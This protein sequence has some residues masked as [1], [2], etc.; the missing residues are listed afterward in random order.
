MRCTAFA[1]KVYRIVSEI[2][3]G[4]V[5]TYQ[6]VAKK[7]GNP[8]AARAVGQLMKRNPYPLIVPCHRVVAAKGLGGYALGLKMKKGLLELEKEIKKSMI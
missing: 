2:P 5:R 6:W 1:R 3:L 4:E 7:A 8:R